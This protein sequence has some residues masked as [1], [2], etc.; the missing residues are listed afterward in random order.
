MEEGDREKLLKNLVS[1][2]KEVDVG[3]VLPCLIA[4][5]I[6]TDHVYMLLAAS[7]VERQ[8]DLKWHKLVV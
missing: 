7:L 6:L 8:H 4:T 5:G 3:G 1:L 2:S